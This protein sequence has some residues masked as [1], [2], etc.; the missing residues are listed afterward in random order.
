MFRDPDDK[1]L[2]G[3]CSGIANHFDFDP[4]YLRGAFAV[5]FFAFGSGFLLYILLWI[6]IP[7][8]QT[9]AE[10]LEMRGEPINV[11]NI[12]RSVE[13]ELN[14]VKNRVNDLGKQSTHTRK[15]SKI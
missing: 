11:D 4:L 12:K 7:K 10:K 1:I 15:P 5:L 2:G 14:D 9:T 8:A 3:V 13:E 6:I